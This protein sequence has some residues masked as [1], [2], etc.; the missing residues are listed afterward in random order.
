VLV[1]LI[2]AA[3][4]LMSFLPQMPAHVRTDTIGY[5]EWLSSVR[6]EFGRWATPLEAVGA[7][8]VN[9]TVWFR[10]LLSLL[11]F[12]LLISIGNHLGTTLRPPGVI[13]QDSYYDAPA[14]MTLTST[15]PPPDVAGAVLGMME[16]LFAR[17]R[18]KDDGPASYMVGSRGH[19]LSASIGV[20]Y[21]GLLLITAGLAINGR[22][23][24]QQAG[25][26]IL[27]DETVSLG[28]RGTHKVQ[29]ATSSATDDEVT[30]YVADDRQVAVAQ[31]SAARWDGY[32]YQLT[33]RGGPLV[34]VSARRNSGEALD[35]YHYGVRPK[36]AQSLRFAFPS[37]QSPDE[38]DRL[39]IVSTE[40]VVGRLA[41]LGTGASTSD[42]EPRFHLWVFREDGQTLLGEQQVIAD[43]G[44]VE[45]TIGGID[46]LLD[47]SRFYVV[48]VA[49]QPGLRFLGFGA[50]LLVGGLVLGSLPQ[51]SMWSAVFAQQDDVRIAIR[52]QSRGFALPYRR[53]RDKAVAHLGLRLEGRGEGE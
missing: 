42:N 28:P 1:L 24:W 19:W 17:V 22:W 13:Q 46:F 16:T 7:F 26:Q 29:L 15:L 48:D 21:L 51:Q 32:R 49:Y 47:L 30:L 50:L 43:D 40:R 52:E 37:T 36:P 3:V 44:A 38:S 41:R 12:V 18:R 45:I 6:A 31:G 27:P 23:G 33:D 20:I 25:V 35:L 5:E 8:W 10:V 39:F 14:A 4:A 34:K 53:R 11:A 9:D 2:A